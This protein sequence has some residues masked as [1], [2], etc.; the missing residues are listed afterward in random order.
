MKVQQY[1]VSLTLLASFSVHLVLAHHE[2]KGTGETELH[3]RS[4]ATQGNS[5][6][7]NTSHDE[8][9][10]VLNQSSRQL[11]LLDDWA[12]CNSSNQC[13]NG[14]CTSHFSVSDGKLKCA[15]IGGFD[16]KICITSDQPVPHP[17]VATVRTAVTG[18]A[19]YIGY[20]EWTW[21]WSLDGQ[22]PVNHT[23]ENFSI[24]FSG[25]ADTISALSESETVY[26]SL[27]GE[28]FI[29]IG[30]GNDNGRWTA[31]AISS[32]DSAINAGLLRHYAGIV[33][34]IEEGDSGLAQAFA[35]SFALAK[36]RGLKVIVTV[37]H[38]APYG[39]EDS[40]TLMH[41][42][43]SNTN[44]DAISP[45]LYTIG[46]E[47]SNDYSESGGVS[48]SDYKNAR[49]AIVPSLISGG[50]YYTD[51]QNVF[52]NEHMIRIQGYIKWSQ[53]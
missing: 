2:G 5:E 36:S 13:R 22:S 4:A 7:K 40:Y 52:E 9:S 46:D 47:D 31:S 43:F 17:Q 34:D 16:T 39:I 48:W 30:G 6:R 50:S 26:T 38:S 45:Q 11:Q 49:Q 18:Q 8:H 27:R 21:T 32:L 20:Y 37:S 41:S 42:F 12:F 24:A 33:Y 10:G 19:L 35:N 1:L 15:P 25:M 44:I 28:R 23:D 51:A 3:L 29:C 53:I 14:C